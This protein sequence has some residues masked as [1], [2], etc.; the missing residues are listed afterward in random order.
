MHD[1]VHSLRLLIVS[2]LLM[3]LAGCWIPENFDTKITINKDGSYTFSY[4]GTL[5]FGLALAAAKQGALSAGD[6]AE[7]RKE[8]EKLRREPGFKKVDYQGKGR[9]KVLYEKAGNRGVP[10]YF[11]SQEMK[12]FAILPQ[13][14]RT[15]TVT[16]VRP[17][18]EDVQQLNSIG[19]KIEG[20]LS[21]S[22]ANGVQVV[23]HN[24]E[25]EPIFF[26]L[27]GAYKWQIKSPSADPVIVV[28]PSS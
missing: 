27:F 4:D 28:K 3:V 19:A 8:G 20:A 5:T 7:F 10:F 9:Y 23:K 6:E 21:V 12:F 14:D 15:V 26:G 16:A 2:I 22:V 17:S 11:V 18:A 25:S 13:A 24:A 1:R